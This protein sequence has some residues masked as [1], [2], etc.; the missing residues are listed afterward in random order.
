MENS[1]LTYEE[2]IFRRGICSFSF[3]NNLPPSSLWE[4]CWRERSLSSSAERERE[5]FAF[6][7]VMRSTCHL[8]SYKRWKLLEM[9]ALCVLS[10]IVRCCL[11]IWEVRNSKDRL[12]RTNKIKICHYYMMT[13]SQAPNAERI[14]PILTP[15]ITFW[16]FV[17]NFTHPKFGV[18]IK[19][20]EQ[21]IVV[22]RHSDH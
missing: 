13:F 7:A 3:S 16:G 22:R 12:W 6:R 18:K 20:V 11:S 19:L 17:W 14:A 10:G 15:Q 2:R 9:F 21:V 4:R 8:F 5:C 1:K